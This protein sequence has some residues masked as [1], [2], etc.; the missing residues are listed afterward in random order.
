MYAMAK[1][2][3]K[4]TGKY[5]H[6]P[7]ASTLE[8]ATIIGPE[9]QGGCQA[10]YDED[11]PGDKDLVV[12]MNSSAWFS[13]R[14]YYPEDYN[15]QLRGWLADAN[16]RHNRVRIVLMQTAV[17]AQWIAVQDTPDEPIKD[18][19]LAKIVAK[20]PAKGD[21]DNLEFPTEL[22]AF[23]AHGAK[24][25][26]YS[27]NFNIVGSLTCE[28]GPSNIRCWEDPEWREM[29]HCDGVKYMLGIKCDW[30]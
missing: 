11:G 12:P 2:I 30:A 6:L 28:D 14:S 29:S 25:C 18:F 17:G 15:R 5:P 7:I 22:P 23:E 26:V 27:G 4:I 10:P 1:T 19:C 9:D 24:G 16:P 20:V 21:E 13:G 3:Q 8:G